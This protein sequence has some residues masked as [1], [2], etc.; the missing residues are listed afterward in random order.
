[1]GE[2]ADAP[3]ARP[4]VSGNTIQRLFLRPFSPRSTLSTGRFA[5]ISTATQARSRSRRAARR[6]RTDTGGSVGG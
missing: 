6:R 1:V 4:F 2:G 3:V 5:T